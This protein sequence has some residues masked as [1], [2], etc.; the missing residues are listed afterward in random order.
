MACQSGLEEVVKLL[1]EKGADPNKY[2]MIGSALLFTS[3]L[4]NIKGLES[5]IF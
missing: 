2:N 1:L 4:N 3:L 5:L